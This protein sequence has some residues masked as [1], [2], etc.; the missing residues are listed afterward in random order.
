M[1]ASFNSFDYVSY[2][3]DLSGFSTVLKLLGDFLKV[4]RIKTKANFLFVDSY[5]S[6]ISR[7]FYKKK[8]RSL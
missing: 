3:N 6:E 2:K 7:K 1:H 5:E 4:V 8:Q